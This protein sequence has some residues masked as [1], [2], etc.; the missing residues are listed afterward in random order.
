MIRYIEYVYLVLALMIVVFMGLNARHMAT[1]QIALTALGA[2]IS[3]FMFSFR[4]AQR[5]SYE[6]RE[7]EE[8]EEMKRKAEDHG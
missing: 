7:Q 2:F 5:Q 8:L 3:A 4:R 6:K 1:H